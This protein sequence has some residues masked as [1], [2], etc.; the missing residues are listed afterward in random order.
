VE[1]KSILSGLLALAPGINSI[2]ALVKQS[3]G[4]KRELLRELQNNINQISLYVENG[5]DAEGIDKRIMALQ[6]QCYEA[7]S[8]A[9]FDFNSLRKGRMTAAMLKAT[10]QFK[11][12]A[13]LGTEQL[14][15]KLYMW[16]H[17]L[18]IIVKDYP[19]SPKFRKR[20][21]L[22]NI[23]KLMLLLAKHIEARD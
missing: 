6:V 3:R 2:N 14:F 13:G 17:Q 5:A 16:I 15:D 20:V 4:Q 12:Y 22:I 23:W 1:I 7:A 11:V 18:K 19:N 10:P 21:R 8:K 9:G